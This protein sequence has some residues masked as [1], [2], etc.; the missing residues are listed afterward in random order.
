MGNGA[1]TQLMCLRSR[2][3]SVGVE[4]VNISFCRDSM[5]TAWRRATG[6]WWPGRTRNSEVT[7][8]D[9]A[10]RSA[11]LLHQPEL[12]LSIPSC[13]GTV[14]N[15]LVGHWHTVGRCGIHHFI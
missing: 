4:N 15:E 14:F 12:S 1:T 11:E 5:G 7:V 8:H 6:M 2:A 9:V 3:I 13:H 10:C